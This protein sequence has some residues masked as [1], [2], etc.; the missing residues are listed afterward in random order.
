[1]L[2]SGHGRPLTFGAMGYPPPRRGACAFPRGAWEREIDGHA[3]LWV[4]TG[5]RGLG[6]TVAR[7]KR[8]TGLPGVGFAHPTK[9]CRHGRGGGPGFKMGPEF[10]RRRLPPVFR[11]RFFPLVLLFLAVTLSTTCT[12]TTDPPNDP[13]PG[14]RRNSTR[15]LSSVSAWTRRGAC[16]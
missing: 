12:P 10:A 9:P 6:A 11:D 7:Q 3:A 8:S 4:F 13:S 14:S 1:M 2:I 15:R 16:W 5:H